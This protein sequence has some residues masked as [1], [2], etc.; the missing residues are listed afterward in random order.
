L[1][2]VLN[3]LIHNANSTQCFLFGSIVVSAWLLENRMFAQP[4]REKLRHTSINVLFLCAALPIQLTMMLLCVG[5]ARW[6]TRNHWGLIYLLPDANSPWIRYGL[7]FF[8]L[9]FLDY[10]YHTTMHRVGFLWKFHLLHHTDQLVD[11][12]T[13][14]REHPG[15]TLIRNLFLMLWVF[16]CGAS[17]EILILRQTVETVAN[18]SQHTKFPLPFAA[19]R[20]F[21]WL[22]VTPNL[23][24]AHHHFRLPGT[25]CNYG[26]V[27]SIWDRIFGTYVEFA[28]EHI[29]FGLDTHMAPN[30]E[31]LPKIMQRG[32]AHLRRQTRWVLLPARPPA[33]RAFR[34]LRQG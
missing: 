11:V 13:T 33:G 34:D 20:L 6:V 18:V 5:V 12:S 29:V 28:H 31:R 19:A 8:L 2:G 23:H 9:D 22:F 4:A 16:L 14:F 32:F 10:V 17:V 1:N 30:A 26:D 15:E 25:N 24:H 7:M 21:G 3:F 27:F